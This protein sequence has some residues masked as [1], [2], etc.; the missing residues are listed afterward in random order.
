M[1]RLWPVFLYLLPLA[2]MGHMKHGGSLWLFFPALAS[3]LLGW[4]LVR[5]VGDT[6]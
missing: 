3:I 5:R 6:T 4:Y 1:S 2:L